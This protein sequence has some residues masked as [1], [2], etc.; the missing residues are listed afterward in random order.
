MQE[1][2]LRLMK[3]NRRGASVLVFAVIVPFF[4]APFDL[5]PPQAGQTGKGSSAFKG[6]AV[7]HSNGQAVAPTHALV[8]VLFGSSVLYDGMPN[9]GDY[10]DS[11][12]LEFENQLASSLAKFKKLAKSYEQG[13]QAQSKDLTGEQTED[14]INLL[15]GFMLQNDDQ[16]LAATMEWAQKQRKKSWQVKI[17]TPEADGKWFVGDLT[18]GI[19]MIFV[20]AQFG[21]Y[22]VEWKAEMH[23]KPNQTLTMP[24]APSLIYERPL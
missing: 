17:I 13:L 1:F 10:I 21:K 4:L 2:V 18:P 11:A 8:W 7:V 15:R 19:Y 6:E 5:Y 9:R 14:N 3:L 12:V 22:D 23:V 24:Q 16:A 20:R